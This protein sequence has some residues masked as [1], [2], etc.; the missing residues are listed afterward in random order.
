MA[1]NQMRP[2]NEQKEKMKT[3]H[4]TERQKLDA[5]QRQRNEQETKELSLIHI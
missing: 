4:Q 5:G 1:A 2:L 3:Q